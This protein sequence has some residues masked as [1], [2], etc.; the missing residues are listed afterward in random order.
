MPS[1]EYSDFRDDPNYT[2]MDGMIVVEPDENLT[3]DELI[4]NNLFIQIDN[5]ETTTEENN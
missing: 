1:N 4:N 2:D 3:L 5:P